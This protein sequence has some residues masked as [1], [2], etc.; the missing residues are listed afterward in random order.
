MLRRASLRSSGVHQGFCQPGQSG[1]KFFLIFQISLQE[2]FQFIKPQPGGQD[3]G[4][5]IL[6]DL[7]ADEMA[8]RCDQ[9]CIIRLISRVGIQEAF[10]SFL[11]DHLPHAQTP[12]SIK[13]LANQ[14]GHALKPLYLLSTFLQPIR[15]QNPQLR[16][17]GCAS[18]FRQFLECLF[19]GAVKAPQFLME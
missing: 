5:F 17:T 13:A 18:H 11:L 19:F 15:E 1:G 12:S 14:P 4:Q 8:R 16:V 6:F 9:A 3:A 7:I 10:P 2:E